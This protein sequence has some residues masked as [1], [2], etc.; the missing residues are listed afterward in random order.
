MEAL[1]KVAAL[2]AI[3][4]A[5]GLG[6]AACATVDKAAIGEAIA[7][8]KV[9]QAAIGVEAVVATLANSFAVV[10]A[11]PKAEVDRVKLA[12]QVD[13]VSQILDKA[14][15]TVD[16]RRGGVSGLV[17]EAFNLVSDAA[18]PSAS[19]SARFAISA[20]FTG[21]QVYAATLDTQALPA[22][23]SPA[24]TQARERTDAALAA[25]RA[26]LPPPGS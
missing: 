5:S 24:L 14:R 13:Q 25:L 1:L 21:L 4:L 19:M 8:P 9:D 15:Q 23:P 3:V 10:V 11:D 22:T 17:G 12:R 20:A 6:L 16:A 7:S 18:P 2:A 26:K